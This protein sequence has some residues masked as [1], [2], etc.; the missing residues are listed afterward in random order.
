MNFINNLKQT[1]SFKLLSISGYLIFLFLLFGH[2]ILYPYDYK[3]SIDKEFGGADAI[4]F[5]SI[6]IY[7]YCLLVIGLFV[8][9][10]IEYLIRKK[11]NRFKENKTNIFTY[12]FILGL[13]GVA[14]IILKISYVVF[15]LP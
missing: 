2:F 10:F 13:S 3:H 9:G 8:F 5:I 14:A 6:I 15:I 4:L 12:L 1:I 11:R 7:N